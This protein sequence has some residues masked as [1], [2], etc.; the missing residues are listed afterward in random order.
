MSSMAACAHGA[1]S[2]CPLTLFLGP[3]GQ[4]GHLIV[5]HVREVVG[6]PAGGGP[7]LAG[8]LRRQGVWLVRGEGLLSPGLHA[9]SPRSSTCV[10][11]HR[12][13]SLA[14]RTR[15]WEAGSLVSPRG[16]ESPR[17]MGGWWEAR[18]RVW[19]CLSRRSL[20]PVCK[21]QCLRRQVWELHVPGTAASSLV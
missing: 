5:C 12:P 10:P 17:G 21:P 20:S 1:P 15:T 8:A 18:A 6:S 14:G 3:A 4:P 13:A 7:S 11:R 2:T 16:L 19:P 9:G